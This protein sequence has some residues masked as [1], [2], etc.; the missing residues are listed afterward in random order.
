MMTYVFWPV[1]GW[2]Q[3]GFGFTR[4]S[5]LRFLT[6]QKYFCL[7]ILIGFYLVV[8]TKYGELGERFPFEVTYVVSSVHITWLMLISHSQLCGASINRIRRLSYLFPNK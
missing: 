3:R 6:A 4:V 1:V 5:E 2:H 7:P 8:F